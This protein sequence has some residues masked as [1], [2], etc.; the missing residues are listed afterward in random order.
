MDGIIPEAPPVPVPPEP[1]FTINSQKVELEIDFAAQTLRGKTELEI[2]PDSTELRAVKLHARQLRLKRLTVNGRAASVTYN[3]PYETTKIFSQAT[4]KQHHQLSQ[5]LDPH[6]KSKPEEDL[7]IHL[8]KQI[9]I[10]EL[11]QNASQIPIPSRATNGIVAS[12]VAEQPSAN[13]DTAIARFTP[14]TISIEYVVEKVKDVLHFVGCDQG[15]GQFPHVYTQNWMRPGSACCLFP[16]VDDLQARCAWEISIKVPTTLATAFIQRTN[17]SGQKNQS[18]IG[19]G[20]SA[21]SAMNRELTVVCSGDLMD[22]TIDKTDPN[23]KIVSFACPYLLAARQI[24]FAVGP[25]EHVNLAEFRDSQEDDELGQTATDIHAYCLPNR[26]DEMRNVCLPMAKAVDFLTKKYGSCPFPN[27]NMVFVDEAIHDTNVVASLNICSSRL[28]YP[29]DI[30]DPSDSITRQLVHAI[31][32]QYV[33]INIVP[34][35]DSDWWVIVG[36]A[37]FMTDTFMRDLCGLNEYRYRLKLHAARVCELDIE[38]P[39]LADTGAFIHVDPSE[40]DFMALKAPLVLFILDRRI[41]KVTGSSKMPGII[42]KIFIRNTTG[43]LTNGALSTEFFQKTCEK[44]YHA[45]IDDFLSQWVHGGGCPQFQVGQRFNKKKLVVEMSIKQMQADRHID[46]RLRPGNFIRDLKEDLNDVYAA[47]VQRVFTGPMTIRI[48][49][50]DGTPYEHIVDVKEAVTRFEIPYNTKYKRLKRGKK[51]REKGT[52]ANADGTDG[53]DDVLLYSLG[54]TLQSEEDMKDWRITEWSREE[55]E[56][57]NSESYEWIRLDADF[58]WIADIRIIMPGYMFLS[59][60]QQDRDIVAQTES[61]QHICRYEAN[62]LISS[63]LLRTLMDKRYFHGIRSTAVGGLARHATPQTGYIGLY[64]LKKVFEEFFC[65]GTTAKMTRP[66]NFSDLPSYH[67]QC[68]I[69]EA[70][71]KVR[72]GDGMAPQEVMDFLLDKLKFNDNSANEYSDCYYV[73]T[74][75]RAMTEALISRNRQPTDDPNDDFDYMGNRRLAQSCMAELDRYRRMDEWT[76]SY[77]N[78][79]S[80]TAVECQRK[81]VLAGVASLSIM[82]FLQYTRPQNLDML[83]VAA[84][85]SLVDDKFFTKREVLSWFLFT[86][87]TDRSP[88]VRSKLRDVFGFAMASAAIGGESKE[89]KQISQDDLVIEGGPSVE[90]QRENAA[91]KETVDGAITALHKLMEHNEDVMHFLWAAVRSNRIG[92][93]EMADLLLFAQAMFEPK[94]GCLIT[95]RYPRYWKVKNLGQVSSIATVASRLLLISVIRASFA[96]HT[97]KSS[98]LEWCRR[99]S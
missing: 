95:L 85:E 80:R 89:D 50:A 6:L 97:P 28:L 19:K 15:S 77:Q 67:I 58:E 43:E 82:H 42:S 13:A 91:R 36:I 25:F 40:L 34:K 98:E 75:M 27:Y 57:M 31:A 84:F 44:V 48:H 59:Q 96:F 51:Q 61:I 8:P 54:D 12:E 11:R 3:D 33:G 83:R 62:P 90:E 65:V 63:I 30:I 64:H 41:A 18:G 37:G 47:P 70:I 56:K 2:F 76:S 17:T 69:I 1:S 79:Y 24:G 66:N 99:N 93:L 21:T 45:R 53:Q 23:K 14:L 94:T 92:F 35:E 74:M 9:R 5:K 26:V 32:W 4:I 60:L 52:N 10:Q 68:A 29:E 72:D 7:R 46:R 39:S 49:E 20:T 55:E 73:A 87:S 78:I 16:C 86:L 22:D 81:L 88:W 71:A 38:R